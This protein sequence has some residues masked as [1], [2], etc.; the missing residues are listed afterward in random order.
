METSADRIAKNEAVFRD[1]NERVEEIAEAFDV[2]D[3]NES[4]LDLFCECGDRSCLER[5]RLTRDEYEHIRAAPTRFVILP[6][7]DVPAIEKVVAEHDG[8]A[9][10]EKF[11]DQAAKIAVETDPRA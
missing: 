9:V 11:A 2:L 7:H 8:F 10:V 3:E 6:G 4:G 1:V 5:I